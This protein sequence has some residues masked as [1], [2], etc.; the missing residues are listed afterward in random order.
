MSILLAQIKRLWTSVSK[1]F[2]ASTGVI[3]EGTGT[4]IKT[5]G[6]VI[7]VGLSS[8]ALLGFIILIALVAVPYGALADTESKPEDPADTEPE[9]PDE[10]NAEFQ[11]IDHCV[12]CGVTDVHLRTADTKTYCQ[13]CYNQ[14]LQDTGASDVE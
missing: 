14:M 13:E 8:V 5:I 1:I 6:S 2:G 9:D 10:I 12:T 4:V 11:V 3:T 7:A